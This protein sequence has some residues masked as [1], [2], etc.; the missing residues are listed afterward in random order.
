MLSKLNLPVSLYRFYTVT[1]R[2]FKLLTCDSHYVS[3]GWCC[4]T[5]CVKYW[6]YGDKKNDTL[7]QGTHVCFIRM[8]IKVLSTVSN[9]SG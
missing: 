2:K 6:G 3:L 4:S 8:Y 9:S 1:T 7:L 5:F